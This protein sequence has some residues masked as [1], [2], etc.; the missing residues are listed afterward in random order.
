MNSFVVNLVMFDYLTSPYILFILYNY[1]TRRGNDFMLH[2]RATLL[3]KIAIFVLGASKYN[4]LST[5]VKSV[6]TVSKFNDT[7]H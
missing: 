2:Q 1:N 5:T 4:N 7:F 3:S 6:K